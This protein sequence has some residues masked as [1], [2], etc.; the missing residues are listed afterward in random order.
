MGFT[1]SV[2]PV[3][4]PEPVALYMYAFCIV[5]S[6]TT[7]SN[8]LSASMSTK[9]TLCDEARSTLFSSVKAP[10][11]RMYSVVVSSDNPMTSCVSFSSIFV[12]TMRPLTT[13]SMPHVRLT[14]PALFPCGTTTVRLTAALPRRGSV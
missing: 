13:M 8:L 14:P 6:T 7:M 5:L 3:Y 12:S 11:T 10:P 9:V 2:M 4:L 1:A